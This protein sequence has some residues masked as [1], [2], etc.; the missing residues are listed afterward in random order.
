MKLSVLIVWLF[1]YSVA[2]SNNVENSKTN[3]QIDNPLFTQEEKEY[4]KKKKVIKMCIV[5]DS[6]PIEFFE[7][8]KHQGVVGDIFTIFKSHLPIPIK[9]VPVHDTQEA[10]KNIS[11]GNCDIKSLVIKEAIP[12]SYILTT[13]PYLSDSLVLMTTND[14]PYI[15]NLH[16]NLK[17]KKFVV[18]HKAYQIFLQK[19]FPYLK[20]IEV[21]GDQKKIAELLEEDEIYGYIDL[22]MIS[23]HFIE[24]FSLNKSVKVNSKIEQI[25]NVSIGIKDTEKPLLTIFNKLIQKLSKE[26][27][28]NLKNSTTVFY[29]AKEIDNTLLWRAL[30]VFFVL[31]G[32]VFVFILKQIRL[33]N[34]IKEQKE[35]FEKLYLKSSDCII[36][37]ENN[38]FIDCNEATLAMLEYDTKEQLFGLNPSAISPQYQPDGRLSSEKAK[39]MI[40]ATIQNGSHKFEWVHTKSNDEEF[41]VEVVLTTI[42]LANK[43]IIH[44]LWRNIDERK[45]LEHQSKLLAH[46]SKKAALGRL[47]SL[48][49]HQWRQ[50]LS[51]INGITSQTYHDLGNPNVERGEIKTKLLQIEN[52]TGDLS[53]AI[54]KIHDFYVYDEDTNEAG[55]TIKE[56]IDECV[57][58]LYPSFANSLQP[59]L[60]INEIDSIKISGYT[61]G[62]HQIIL[63]LL[64][65][66]EEIFALRNIVNPLI[67]IDLYKANG[68]SYIALKDNGGGIEK[69][70]EEKIFEPFVSSKNRTNRIR[71]LGLSIAKDIVV[72]HLKGTI[73]AANFEEGAIFTIRYKEYD[74]Q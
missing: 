29:Q 11:N 30:G 73:Q 51:M 37:A 48:I 17:N 40:D 58:I 24:H 52:I 26:Y 25:I 67:T 74:K 4:L 43:N 33:K 70:I 16:E 22:A 20:N 63:T 14:K 12:Y 32:I 31:F 55:T 3:T 23:N 56:I 45:K 2:L 41:W 1:L 54:N 9:I 42:K 47:I 5:E 72:N 15:Q 13:N 10:Q 66:C 64:T 69:E 34:E 18:R 21:I 44:A 71:G 57:E 53:K 6:R 59:H 50:P 46:Q 36:L 27:I 62:M 8:G 7:N 38:I 28:Q 61:Y 65:N 39:E 49:A 19:Y 68:F 35:T 60:I